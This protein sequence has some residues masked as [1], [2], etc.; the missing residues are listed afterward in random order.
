MAAEKK[1]KIVSSENE[2]EDGQIQPFDEDSLQNQLLVNSNRELSLVSD[3]TR[4]TFNSQVNLIKNNL[5]RF[6]SV[7]LEAGSIIENV[8]LINQ[9]MN[10]VVQNAE[11]SS[12]FLVKVDSKMH[13]L[14]QQF[15]AVD[16]LLKSINFIAGQTNILALNA[17][18]E[19]ARAGDAGKGFAVV[20]NEVKDLSKNTKDANEA[21][22]K[23][24]SS[25]GGSIKELSASI[26][27]VNTRMKESSESVSMSQQH[28]YEIREK[29]LN[30]KEAIH[31]S[32]IEFEELDKNSLKA[33]IDINELGSISDTVSALLELV[34]MR[35]KPNEVDPLVRLA[36]L[37]K[38]STDN[39]SERFSQS[40]EEY[41]LKEDDILISA[42]DTKGIIQ[43]ANNPFY[44]VAQYNVGSLYKK[45]HNII[46]HPDM[47]MT[48]FADLWTNLKK[49]KIWQG[50]VCNRGKLGRIY[51]V[52]AIVFPNYKD[53]VLQGYISVRS[54]PSRDKVEKA[55]EAYRLL[56]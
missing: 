23:L 30:F 1:L 2:Y 22:Q 28:V 45:P 25:I 4:E 8:E 14:E 56:L 7:V 33:E 26:H 54:K 17:T 20:A 15:T 53:G 19:A 38:N 21:I 44:K 50:Y 32:Q 34:N 27:E 49:G 6:Q 51:W 43:F 39:F 13:S 29:A 47:P 35:N 36:P 46:R 42:T 12:Q 55:K 11:T 16:S 3:E 9:D 40:E 41:V 5:S 52:K 48:A 24:I 37:V 18:I 10:K 31:H